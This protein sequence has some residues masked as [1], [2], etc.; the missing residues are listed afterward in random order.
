ML[1]QKYFSSNVLSVVPRSSV[2]PG[3]P[4][5]VILTKFSNAGAPF[6]MILYEFLRECFSGDSSGEFIIGSSEVWF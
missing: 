5:A 4:L 6:K 3:I 2:A 1:L